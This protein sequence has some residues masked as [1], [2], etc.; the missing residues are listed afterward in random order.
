MNPL[1]WQLIAVLICVAI[2]AWSLLSRFRRLLSGKGGSPCGD[3]EKAKP[4]AGESASSDLVDADQI[5]L[6]YDTQKQSGTSE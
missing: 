1:N 4:S 2:A 6:L 3:C 5:E